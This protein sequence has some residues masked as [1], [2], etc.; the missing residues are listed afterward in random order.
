MR[1]ENPS[2]LEQRFSSVLTED[3]SFGSQVSYVAN[4]NEPI[5]R[6]FRFK[7]AFGASFVRRAIEI[8]RLN[9]KDY[10]LDPWYG[11]GTTLSL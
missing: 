9:G 3:R 8:M 7:E 10:V 6:W 2:S 4:K 11:M 1:G 5:L